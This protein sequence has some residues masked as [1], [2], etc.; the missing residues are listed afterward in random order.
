[1]KSTFPEQL[2][3]RHPFLW[4]NPKSAHAGDVIAHL[5]LHHNLGL[6]DMIKADALLRRW[7]TTLVSLFP[8]T[9]ATKGLIES[10]LVN[11]ENTDLI[12]GSAFGG[13]F[14]IKSDHSLPVAGSI[15][16]RGGFYEVLLHAENLAR[17]HGIFDSNDDPS[18]LLTEKARTL[19]SKHSISV[20]STGNLGISIG[21]MASSLGFQSIVHMSREAKEWKKRHLREHGVQV[22]EHTGDYEA[23]VASGRSACQQDATCYFVDDENS[24][25]LFLGYSVAALRLKDQLQEAGVQV[26]AGHPL[27]VYLPCG[28]GGAPGGITWGLK[29][30]FGDS[31]H[32]FFAEPTASPSMLVRLLSGERSLSV[33]DVGLDNKTEADGLAVARASEFAY[34]MIH[35]LV[36]GAYTVCDDDLFVTLAA[37]ERSQGLRIEPSAAAC[38][39]GYRFFVTGHGA[40][41]LR[42]TLK[43]RP[44]YN[45]THIFWTTGG[46]LVPDD[47]YCRWFE[48]VNP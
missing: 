14:L 30:L 48:R 41:Y 17:Q 25:N 4:V 20:G 19:F 16:A 38:F 15:K 23:A 24:R 46:G 5:Q 9:V 45:A 36:D 42:R 37:L 34:Q 18:V 39:L 43:G 6:D 29:T 10:S 33:Y 7:R 47:E 40:Q 28:V 13:R 35:Q 32:C 12:G 2:I 8:D 11:L 26:D 22:I 44:T 1:M 21:I 3:H 27:F 31:V